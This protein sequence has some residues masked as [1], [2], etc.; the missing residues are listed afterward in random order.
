MSDSRLLALILVFAPV[1]ILSFGGGQFD[2]QSMTRIS[3]YTR[4]AAVAAVYLVLFAVLRV[5]A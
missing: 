3:T 2:H 1:S 4:V 5:P